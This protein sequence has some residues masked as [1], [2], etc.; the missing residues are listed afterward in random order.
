MAAAPSD[1]LKGRPDELPEVLDTAQVAQLLSLSIDYVRKKSREGV[2]PAH[3][4]PRGREYRYFKGEILEWLRRQPA[5]DAP[6]D[7]DSA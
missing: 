7:G 1:P 4:I 3:K 5:R 2:I 6:P